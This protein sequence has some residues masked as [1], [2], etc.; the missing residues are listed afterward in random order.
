L[1]PRVHRNWPGFREALAHEQAAE[2]LER[3]STI[4]FGEQDESL[5]V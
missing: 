2:L 4:E 5:S 1:N 3:F